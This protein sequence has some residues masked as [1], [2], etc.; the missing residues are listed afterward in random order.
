MSEATAALTGATEASS[1]DNGSTNGGA[2]DTSTNNV[3]DVNAGSSW[4][5]GFD[6]ETSAYVTNKGWEGP[7]SMLES[8]RNLEKLA[9]GN[10]NIL[11]MPGVDAT[12][13]QMSDFY[14]RL[15]RPETAADYSFDL[16][17]G[18]DGDMLDWFKTTAHKHGLSDNQAKDL[19]AD[20]EAMAG[21]R[22]ENATND[23]R[24]QSE[25]DI[26]DLQK[27]WGRDYEKNVDSGKRA[28]N[29]LGYDEQSL[30]SLENKMGTSEMLKLFSQIGSKMG[31]DAFVD[32]DSDG[33]GFGGSPAAARQQL[34]DLRLDKSFMDKYMSGDKDAINKF[35]RLMEKTHG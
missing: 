8:Y 16:P 18:G 34:A 27:E 9:G 13:E 28:V 4:K 31:E 11:E 15:G 35:T 12:D 32:G 19:F 10:K 2:I 20:Y 1:S 24:Q 6:E 7:D 33:S 14:N 5:E 26:S 22:V 3:A 23:L 25:T 29:A 30:S 17:E 21:D